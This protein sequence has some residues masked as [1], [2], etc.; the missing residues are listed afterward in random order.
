MEF[1]K[2]PLQR[3]NFRSRV[4]KLK[5]SMCGSYDSPHTNDDSNGFGSQSMD[6]NISVSLQTEKKEE[7]VFIEEATEGLETSRDPD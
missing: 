2:D 7:T 4:E 1:W 6:S 5:R 3:D